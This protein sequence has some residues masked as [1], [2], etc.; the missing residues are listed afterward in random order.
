MRNL[1]TFIAAL[2]AAS[3]FGATLLWD[4]NP[5]V[6]VVGYRV[7]YG[8]LSRQYASVTNVGNNTNWRIRSVYGTNYFAVTAYD[9]DGLESDFSNEVWYYRPPYTNAPRP[10]T[11]AVPTNKWWVVAGP[12]V[13]SMTNWFSVTGP[14]NVVMWSTNGPM[15]FMGRKAFYTALMQMQSKGGATALMPTKLSIAAARTK[16]VKA[17]D[18]AVGTAPRLTGPKPQAPRPPTLPALPK[19]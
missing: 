6:D 11:L 2:C 13:A 3:S 14:T 12:D 15:Q 4:R 10:I 8:V 19:S 18:T 1:L 9:A 17:K 7:Y 5:E 16:K